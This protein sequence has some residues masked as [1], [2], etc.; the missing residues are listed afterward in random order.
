[1]VALKEMLKVSGG[2]TNIFS[3]C[4]HRNIV[5]TFL[6]SISESGVGWEVK[7]ADKL[8]Q[9]MAATVTQVD[10]QPTNLSIYLL[11]LLHSSPRREALL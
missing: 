9:Q 7:E 11:Y 3:H 5:S 4:R 8:D 1:M 6:C 2:K 10:L